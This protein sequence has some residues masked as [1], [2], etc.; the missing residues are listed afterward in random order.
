MA[1]TYRIKRRVLA[2]QRFDSNVWYSKDTF[3]SAAEDF[4][5][6]PINRR[7]FTLSPADECMAEGFLCANLNDAIGYVI[8][9][10]DCSITVSI[11]DDEYLSP[12]CLMVKHM[13]EKGMIVAKTRGILK[14]YDTKTREID[15]MKIICFEAVPDINYEKEVGNNGTDE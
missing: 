5:K 4:L 3:R 6:K 15:D 10:D 1:T 14:S 7:L 2:G 11:R 8:D 13:I 12:A 9:I